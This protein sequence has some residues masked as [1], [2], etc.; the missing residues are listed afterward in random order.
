MF[1]FQEILTAGGFGNAK[2]PPEACKL[3]AGSI[4]SDAWVRV[5]DDD[6]MAAAVGEGLV[7]LDAAFFAVGAC[8]GTGV[9]FG[10]TKELLLSLTFVLRGF[11]GKIV[12]PE[13]A[14]YKFSRTSTWLAPG[15]TDEIF[16]KI[17]LALPQE[18]ASIITPVLSLPCLRAIPLSSEIV[19]VVTASGLTLIDVKAELAH[20]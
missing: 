8:E 18:R 15:F 12:K 5:A 10:T 16:G 2:E 14:A 9:A 6:A 19:A 11:A 17:F 1:C 20:K 3:S 4:A 13:L 7:V